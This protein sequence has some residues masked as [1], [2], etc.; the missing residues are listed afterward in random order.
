M[1]KTVFAA[2]R[3]CKSHL[4]ENRPAEI[5]KWHSGNSACVATGFEIGCRIGMALMHKS[6]KGQRFP[7]PARTHPLASVMGVP[8]PFALDLDPGAVE[9]KVLRTVRATVSG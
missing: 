6:A 2:A 4:A 1:A 8:F 5:L 9:Q 3:N 7:F